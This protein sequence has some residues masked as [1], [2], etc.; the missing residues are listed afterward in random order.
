MISVDIKSLLAR[1]N[2]FCTRSLEAAAGLCV[3][4]T[5]YEVTVEHMLTKLLEESHADIPLLLRH[6]EIEPGRL[7]QSLDRTLEEFRTGNA[8]KPVFSPLLMEWLQES[9]LIGSVDLTE[10]TIRSGILLLTLLKNPGRFASGGYLDHLIPISKESLQADFWLIIKESVEKT[11][12][13]EDV[14]EAGE[15]FSDGTALGKYC[16]D[17]TAK[18]KDGDIDPVFGRD[19]E[20]RQMIDILAR[21]RKNNPIAVGEPGVGKTAVVEGLAL[22]IVEGDV[23][24]LLQ[25]VTLLG[26]DMGRLQAGAGVKG[27]FENRLKAVINEIKA[28]PKPIILFIDEAHTLIGAGGSAGGSDAANLLKPALARGELRTVAAT[29]WS[30]YKKYFEKDAALARRFQLV[31]L[32]EPSR[33]TSALI[34]RGLKVKY[35]E[36]HGVIV[37]DDAIL[38]AAELSSRYISGRQLPDKA[39]DLLDTSAARVKILLTAKPDVIEDRERSMQALNRERDALERDRTHGIEVDNERLIEIAEELQVLENQVGELTSR[40]REEQGLAARIVQL[41]KVL[42]GDHEEDFTDNVMTDLVEV[43]KELDSISEELE[44]LQDDAPLVRIEVDPDVVAKVVSDWT[45]IPLGRVM[46]DQAAG[47]LDLEERLGRRIK[48]Q[49]MGLQAITEVIKSAKAGLKDPDQPMGIFLLVGP[50][51]VGKTETALSLADVLFGGEQFVTSIN[52]SEFQEQHT[53]S[54]LIGSPPGYVGF[55]EGGV[56]TEAVRQRP[57]SVV[58]LDEVEK[59]NLEVMNLFYQVFDKGVLS[60]GEGRIIDFKNTVIFL[61]SNLATDVITEM[62][63]GE[64]NLPLETLV[65]AIRP[66]LSNHFKPALVARMTVVPYVALQGDV[67]KDIVVLKLDKLA[68]RMVETHKLHFYYG[69][70]VVDQIAA[71]CT[72]VETGARNIDHIMNGTILP[73]ISREILSRMSEMA[74]PSELHLSIGEDGGFSLAFTGE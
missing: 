60:D 37:R 71:R 41:R 73:L 11:V 9:W 22:R 3:S 64:E 24:E 50:S 18:A 51:G 28:S 66:I 56:L 52:M 43:K 63:T 21:R 31:Q 69:E 17:F 42:Y 15:S 44:Q 59:A 5:H 2:P 53:V 48:G 13:R 16:D 34:L 46:R 45:G 8:A 19:Q 58:L 14:P 25:D 49:D 36:A 26:L 7:A 40:W 65:E 72:E 10:R 39:V 35:E 70:D 47:V 67:L 74:L 32:D 4:R 27:E 62:T 30:E 12:S 6:F 38:A 20:I 29:T 61:T 23:P 68:R 33:E 55:G 57:Y 1:L 54:R